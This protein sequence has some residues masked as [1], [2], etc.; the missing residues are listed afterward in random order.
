M[1]F[2]SLPFLVFFAV[3]LAVYWRLPHRAQNLFLLAA[4]L[5][6]YGYWNEWLLLL[7]IGSASID[8][9]CGLAL[10]RAPG[11]RARRAGHRSRPSRCSARGARESAS[12]ESHDGLL[13]RSAP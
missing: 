6:F 7:L 4:S 3:V 1:L 12:R 5:F 10:E 8:Y 13:C 9:V 11:E 2:H